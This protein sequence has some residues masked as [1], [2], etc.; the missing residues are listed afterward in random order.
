M[1]WRASN[2]LLV[3]ERE[4]RFSYVHFWISVERIHSAGTP[5][6]PPICGCVAARAN[7]AVGRGSIVFLWHGN[8][9][10][11][12]MN[13]YSTRGDRIHSVGWLHLFCLEGMVSSVGLADLLSGGIDAKCGLV[14]GG[15]V[16]VAPLYFERMGRCIQRGMSSFVFLAW[17]RKH[18]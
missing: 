10:E 4:Q 6:P 16:G 18:T 14:G 15:S 7:A 12:R 2:I 5:A 3:W 9:G 11:I 8:G 1:L 17:E 13:R